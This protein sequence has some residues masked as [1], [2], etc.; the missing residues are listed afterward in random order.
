MS[1]Y[2]H[3]CGSQNLR[4]SHFRIADTVHLL[5]LQYPVR[6]HSCKKR[7]YAPLR[8]ALQL[9]RPPHRRDPHE[10]LS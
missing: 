10:K 1:I 4:S 2:C 5:V 6:C 7:W 8:E 9:P 3:E